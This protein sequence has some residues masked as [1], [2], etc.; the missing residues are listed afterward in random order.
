M[1]FQGLLVTTNCLRPEAASLAIF[2]VKRG[3]FYNFVKT[4]KGSS[5]M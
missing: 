5:F 1:A 2:A 4:L 3:F